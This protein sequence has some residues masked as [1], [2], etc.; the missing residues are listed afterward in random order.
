MAQPVESATHAEII[1]IT[2]S[3]EQA[4]GALHLW[5]GAFGTVDADGNFVPNPMLR[6][7]KVI[8]RPSE[9]ADFVSF[10]TDTHKVPAAVATAGN[11]RRDDILAY[12]DARGLW[13]RVS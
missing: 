5:I 1:Q 8:I 2:E 9:W 11:W 3:W 13:N 7:G 10:Q 12:V 4:T 6:R